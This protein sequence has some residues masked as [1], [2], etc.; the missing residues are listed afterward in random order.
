LKFCLW[1]ADS[2]PRLPLVKAPRLLHG[3][4]SFYFNY[5]DASPPLAAILPDGSPSRQD[6][7]DMEKRWRSLAR[8]IELSQRLTNFSEITENSGTPRQGKD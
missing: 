7:L 1:R 5:L 6:F 8:S 4:R 2:A 3:A